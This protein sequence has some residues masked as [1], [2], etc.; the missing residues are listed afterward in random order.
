MWSTRVEE[1][2]GGRIR[3]FLVE[4]H[5]KPAT[6]ADVLQGW[7][8]DPAFRSCFNDVLAEAPFA[9]FRWETPPLTTASVD[10]TFEFVLIDAPGLA[11]HPDPSP[12]ASHL[13]GATD[14]GVAVF[15]NLGG[16]A[17]LVIPRSIADPTVYGH[18][19]AFVRGAPERQRDALWQ[20]V[21]EAMA[22]RLNDQPVW[23]NTAGAGVSWLHVRLDDRPKYYGFSPYR[24]RI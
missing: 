8:Y 10:Q 1:L 15:A 18:L 3:R 4:P 7:R 21:G 22:Q 23:L 12:F 14:E 9:A 6:F 2:D 11:R 5:E 20:S 19:G 16:D 24:R 17:L 13:G